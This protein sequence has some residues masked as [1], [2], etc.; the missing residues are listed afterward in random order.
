[1]SALPIGH[2]FPQLAPSILPPPYGSLLISLI[3]R[4]K[5]MNWDAEHDLARPQ[6]SA[7]SLGEIDKPAAQ[8]LRRDP[9]AS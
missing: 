5:S 8:T 4:P 7:P 2:G 6:A 3:Y 9:T 1:M